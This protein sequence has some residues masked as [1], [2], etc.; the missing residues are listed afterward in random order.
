MAQ[1]F[2]YDTATAEKQTGDVFGHW[3]RT[4]T[5]SNNYSPDSPVQGGYITFPN[6]DKFRKTTAYLRRH[7]QINPGAGQVT[8]GRTSSGSERN[9]SAS[10]G[11]YRAD[12]LLSSLCPPFDS[13]I[14]GVDKLYSYP[15]IPLDMRNEAATKALEDIASQSANLGE[16]LAT[17]RQTQNLIAKPAGALLQSLRH[18]RGVGGFGRFLRLSA[19]DIK[20]QGPLT[21]AAEEY[22]K[23][24]YGWKPLMQDIYGIIQFAKQQGNANLLVSGTGTSKRQIQS[25]V[26]THKDL[27]YDALTTLGPLSIE[28]TVRMKIWGRIDPTSAGL[29]SLNQL[30]L[31]NP[32]SLAWDLMPWSFVVDWFVPIGSTL[33]A[34]TAPAGLIFVNGSQSIKVGIS[35]PYEHHN[36]SYDSTAQVN[37]YA[38]GSVTHRSYRRKPVTSWPLPGFWVSQTPFV[39]DRAFKALALS[40][41]R[42]RNLR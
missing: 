40:I 18:V 11:G 39:G 37:S 14:S 26:G 19:R 27:S 38:S 41:V 13:S 25:S 17:F 30:G 36:Y 29:R 4:R 33:N 28:S 42:L 7:C 21:K 8:R 1:K 23:F 5:I 20:R 2:T 12:N 3:S 31:L 9:F 22:L 16:T 35:G 6:G 34:L 32:V 15:D 10:G 24:V